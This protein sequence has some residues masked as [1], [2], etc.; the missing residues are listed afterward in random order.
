[1]LDLVCKYTPFSFQIL[2]NFLLKT[3]FLRRVQESDC[4]ILSE[5]ENFPKESVWHRHAV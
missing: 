4:C 3:D 5:N 2:I 1:M